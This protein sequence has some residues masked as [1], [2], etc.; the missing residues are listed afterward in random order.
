V[1]DTNRPNDRLFDGTPVMPAHGPSPRTG[2][3]RYPRLA[4]VAAQIA[5]VAAQKVMDTGL[6]RHDDVEAAVGQC[7]RPSVLLAFLCGSVPLYY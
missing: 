1:P 7:L 6:R 3:G 4:F 5:F 2:S